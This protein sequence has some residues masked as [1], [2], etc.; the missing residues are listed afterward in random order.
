MR[1]RSPSSMEASRLGSGR[2]AKLKVALLLR[3]GNLCCLCPKIF[4]TE[5]PPTL[6]HV[7]PEADGGMTEMSNLKLAHSSCN[8]KKGLADSM[9]RD[10]VTAEDLLSPTKR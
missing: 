2:K 10:S 8:Q 7:I 6:E 3:D 5:N 1:P 4:T 9:K